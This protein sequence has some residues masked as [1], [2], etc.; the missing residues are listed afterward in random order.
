MRCYLL[1]LCSLFV[2]ASGCRHSNVPTLPASHGQ[3]SLAMDKYL[4]LPTTW[5]G[6]PTPFGVPEGVVD[7]AQA[8][9]VFAEAVQVLRGQPT[10][11]EVRQAAED[12]AAA[13]EAP[14][15]QA[16]DFLREQFKAPKKVEGAFPEYPREALLAQTPGVV[17]IRCRL[18]ADGRLR[19][20]EVLEPA[21][22]GLTE[23]V[24]EASRTWRFQPA[25]LAGHALEIPMT[26]SV[27][28]TPQTV[29]PTPE[30]ML[31]WTR[32]RAERFPKSVAAWFDLAS[33]LAEQAPEDPAYVPALR[34]L[35][36][37]DPSFWWS[38]NELAWMDAR[39]GQYAKAA[40][41]ARRARDTAPRNPYVLEVSAATLMG[42]GQCQEA[43]AAQRQA[44]EGLPD[45]WPA[46]E[47]ERFRNSLREYSTRPCPK[48]P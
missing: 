45:A 8:P 21:A 46:P 13:C 10:E 26:T 40:P 20:C 11:D 1:S 15:Q 27:R 29:K 19:A 7:P 4:E 48:S 39:A 25:S 18:G 38:T 43:I 41:L 22:H 36:E 24:L 30:Q 44:V 37:L 32:Q 35:N 14:F 5:P 17:C 23:S 28:L 33:M 2:L 6:G 42:L 16:C 3:L 47:R 34:R 9:S 31:Q 12:L